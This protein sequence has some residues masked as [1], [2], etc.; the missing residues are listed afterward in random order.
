MTTALANKLDTINMENPPP[1]G[2]SINKDDNN[3]VMDTNLIPVVKRKSNE[4]IIS[5]E[6]HNIFSGDEQAADMEST[7]GQGTQELTNDDINMET[8]TLLTPVVKQEEFLPSDKQISTLDLEN[9]WK[10]NDKEAIPLPP[11][12]RT[13]KLLKLKCSPSGYRQQK[14]SRKYNKLKKKIQNLSLIHISEPTRPY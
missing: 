6:E 10:D 3:I 14:H 7:P 1:R 12:K 4:L 8:I 11:Q 5:T 2:H 9:D 13:K